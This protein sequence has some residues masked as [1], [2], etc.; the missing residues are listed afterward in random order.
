[1]RKTTTAIFSFAHSNAYSLLS[2]ACVCCF[3]ARLTVALTAFWIS[4]II[5]GLSTTLLGEKAWWEP[6]KNAMYCFERILEAAS[7]QNSSCTT[8]CL[9]S[10]KPT[11]ED[12]NDILGSAREQGRTHKRRSLMDSQSRTHQCWPTSKDWHSLALC[13]QKW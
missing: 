1:M 7:H 5:V 12:E 6:H 3:L 8:T 4:K 2:N 13:E 9:S 10:H 11:K